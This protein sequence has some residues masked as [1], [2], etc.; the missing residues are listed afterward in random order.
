V[1]AAVGAAEAE[2]EAEGGSGSGN[3]LLQKKRKRPAEESKPKPKSAPKTAPREEEENV[4]EEDRPIKHKKGAA[5]GG[6]KK[7][8]KRERE[9]E[10]M[11]EEGDGDKKGSTVVAEEDCPEL[12]MGWR[13]V[14]KSRST[15]SAKHVDKYY[16]GP[17]GKQYNSRVK[18]VKAAGLDEDPLVTFAQT[19]KRPLTARD[20][21]KARMQDARTRLASSLNRSQRLYE[22]QKQLLAHTA[23]GGASSASAAAPLP[24]SAEIVGG[25]AASSASSTAMPEPPGRLPLNDASLANDAVALWCFAVSFEGLLH[26]T[27]FTLDDFCAALQRPT[28]SVLLA[29]LHTR[30]LR[31]LLSDV[32]TLRDKWQ[33]TPPLGVALLL[34]QLPPPLAVSATSWPEVLRS[35]CWLL[36]ANEAL[37]SRAAQE[38][39]TALGQREYPALAASHKLAL[40]RALVS[41]YLELGE[42]G[43]ATAQR[44]VLKW[45]EDHV[46]RHKEFMRERREAEAKVKRDVGE[47]AAR[48][49]AKMKRAVAEATYTVSSE[50]LAE[51]M[52]READAA[53]AAQFGGRKGHHAAAIAAAAAAA[54]LPTVPF[55]NPPLDEAYASEDEEGG[56]AVAA[57]AAAAA[58][59]SGPALSEAQLAL[60]QQRQRRQQRQQAT[61]ALLGAIESRAVRELRDAVALATR[62]RHEGETA[63]G[64]PWRS[65]ELR[66]AMR[67]HAEAVAHEE[68]R[69]LADK[70][71]TKMQRVMED[72]LL[73]QAANPTRE[74]PLGSDR[75]GRVYWAFLHDPARLY[76][77]APEARHVDGGPSGTYRKGDDEETGTAGGGAE[78]GGSGGGG[79]VSLAAAGGGGL[80]RSLS[81]SGAW[82]WA[83]YDTVAAVRQVLASLDAENE[84][85]RSLEQRLRERLPL[86]ELS[87]EKELVINQEAGW[88]DEP[89][90]HEWMGIEMLRV[91]MGCISCCKVVR[92]LPPIEAVEGDAI[93]GEGRV[94][95]EKALFHVLHDDGD[96]EDLDEDEAAE[97]RQAWLEHKDKGTLPKPGEN[98]G[99]RY[100][101]KLV[102]KDARLAVEALGVL[103]LRAEVLA[104]EEALY[105]GLCL[106]HSKWGASEGGRSAWLL[107]AKATD[108]TFELA[109]LLVSLEETVRE[110][111]GVAEP[112][113]RKPW[114]TEGH[115]YIN[116]PAR[117]FFASLA[118]GGASHGHS[119]GKIVGWLPPEGEDAALWH[120]V[121]G[122]DADEEDID[123]TEAA[124]AIAN[125]AE[126]RHEPLPEEVEYLA[127]FEA[128]ADADAEGEDEDEDEGADDDGGADADYMAE[129]GGAPRPGHTTRGSE[130]SA[131]RVL[132][133]QKVPKPLWISAESRERWLAVLHA[134]APNVA[135]VGLAVVALRMHCKAFGLMD[136]PP[137][138]K[139]PREDLE[140]QLHSW[141]HAKA[142][143]HMAKGG[144]K[145]KKK[146]PPSKHKKGGR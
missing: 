82:S 85:E 51:A 112:A 47:E 28:P 21:Q 53:H 30:L 108:S 133:G 38:A 50:A 35:V 132:P 101:N 22:V 125:Y 93:T 88:R 77:Q 14:S 119:D 89:G 141:C 70:E 6:G 115:E 58:D 44:P 94:E 120:M 79:G 83:Y 135:S 142:F 139:A 16:F 97:A 121:H 19:S 86:V 73:K 111:Q 46:D 42:A 36:R 65:E 54:P 13:C 66:A 114:R 116:K 33:A 136:G 9:D 118:T 61:E 98:V 122:E 144:A 60:W 110:L 131:P 105:A 99:D 128:K 45:L 34:Q 107:S 92:W 106:Y 113:E 145:G 138:R 32:E 49:E 39:L 62:S 29:E 74:E 67:V 37:E 80:T 95:G 31:G 11:E 87:M 140:L 17:D 55:A 75:R 57:A 102:K 48:I 63:D 1:G 96:E 69:K 27:P 64:K 137:T 5:G 91:H 126:N 24:P 7:G 134:S 26:L 84:P 100:T 129:A 15:G 59:G 52:A 117:R 25:A 72:F 20:R 78:I 76:V 43:P 3:A 71:A 143:G 109:Q 4:D 123:E 18:A 2:D 12:G 56:E 90:G 10:D 23:A 146:G 40:L 124:Y 8:A 127:Q 81:A 103:G 130:R 41:A 68:R 104:L